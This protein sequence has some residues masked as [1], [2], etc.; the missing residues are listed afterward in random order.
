MRISFY[1]ISLFFL[2]IS[3]L[4]AQTDYLINPS[5]EKQFEWD[6]FPYGWTT[7][8]IRCTPDMQPGLFWVYAS[9]TDGNSYLGLIML[10]SLDSDG[11][12]N[13]DICGTLLNPLYRDSVYILSLDVADAPYAYVWENKPQK[14]RISSI[15]SD[16]S[17]IEVF[18]LTKTISHPEWKTYYFIISPKVA[19]CH[20]LKFEI[21]GD[22][23]QPSYML[24]DNIRFGELH[25]SGDINVCKGQQDVVYCLPESEYITDLKWRYTGTGATLTESSNNVSIDFD[26]NATNGELIVKYKINGQKVASDTLHISVESLMPSAAGPIDGEQFVCLWNYRK[27]NTLPIDNADKY[28]WTYSGEDAAITGNSDSISIQYLWQATSGNLYVSG[29]NACGTGIP[30]VLAITVN[31]IPKDAE[32][33]TGSSQIC[34]SQ[35]DVN[36]NV[37]P[38]Q[39]AIDYNWVYSGSGVTINNQGSTVSLSFSDNATSG[40][41]S[42]N[43]INNCGSGNNAI[44]FISVNKIPD[45]IG[46]ISGDN[47]TC[48]GLENEI[49]STPLNNIVTEYIWEYSGT[50]VLINTNK[51]SAELDF[52]SNATSG[53]LTV[54]GKNICGTGMPSVFPITIIGS[55]PSDPGEI[56]GE[57]LVCGYQQEVSYTIPPIENAV[58]YNWNY[59]GTGVTLNTRDNICN[60]YFPNSAVSGFLSINGVNACGAGK[61]SEKFINVTAIPENAANINGDNNVCLGQKKVQYNIPAIKYATDYLWEYTG[62]GATFSGGGN[63]IEIDFSQN[64][65]K[66]LL[67]VSGSN[68]CGTGL[69]SVGFP[70]TVNSLPSSAGI[71]TGETSVCLNYRYLYS[72]TPV[73]NASGYIW[74]YSGTDLPIKDINDSITVFYTKD[75]TSGDLTVAGLNSCGSGEPSPFLFINLTDCGRSIP[76]TFS[77]NVDGINDLFIIKGFENYPAFLVFDRL[78]RKV[79]ESQSYQNDWNGNDIEGKALP[80]DTYWYVLKI[81]EDSEEIKGYIYLKR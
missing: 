38:I 64:A 63:S 37:P 17:L 13:E 68:D 6:Y 27:Y 2:N 8:N 58:T 19:D 46:P 71:I 56:A 73:E 9:P 50:G 74:T 79:Y 60:L 14:L 4:N 44:L 80:T 22:T 81:G 48:R 24:L 72:I 53:N 51:N 76:N 36:Y 28:L 61:V 7:C 67:T 69:S 1:L 70:I 25:I 42:V 11:P 45:N 29:M 18:A 34:G 62:T 30:S 59:E 33:I 26:S 16:C 66:G 49:Y 52:S 40:Y 10:D 31:D 21:Y 47:T 65:S 15:N 54:K 78:G 57:A 41:L 39:Y 32:P 12:K 3:L 20:Y 23:L 77:P 75:F 55:F 5:F 43:G 35:N